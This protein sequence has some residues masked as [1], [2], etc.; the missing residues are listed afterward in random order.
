MYSTFFA[1]IDDFPKNLVF[2]AAGYL[3]TKTFHCL[4]E[5]FTSSREIQV[6]F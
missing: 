5:M 3:T 6:L 1:D 4:Q 2:P